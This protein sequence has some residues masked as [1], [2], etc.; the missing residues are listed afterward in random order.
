MLHYNDKNFSRK[1]QSKKI[2]LMKHLLR[3]KISIYF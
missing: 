3:R 1:M 2:E